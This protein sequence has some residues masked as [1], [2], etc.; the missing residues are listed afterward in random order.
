MS[1]EQTWLIALA[2]SNYNARSREKYCSV[3]PSTH[4][5]D[6]ISERERITSGVERNV[7]AVGNEMESGFKFLIIY[8][9]FLFP[10]A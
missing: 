4:S 2:V 9:V 10:P 8:L 3:P 1:D 7:R 6:L 5:E